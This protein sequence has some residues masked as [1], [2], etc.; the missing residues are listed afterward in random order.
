MQKPDSN[1]VPFCYNQNNLISNVVNVMQPGRTP[2]KEAP[3][4]LFNT[5]LE[6]RLSKGQSKAEVIREVSAAVERKYDNDRFYKWSMQKLTVAEP[7]LLTFI[8][9]ELP[10]VLKHF[11]VKNNYS[12]SGIDFE[13]LANAIRPAVKNLSIQ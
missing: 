5:W 11:Y 8:Y 6:Y 4:N 1:I 13:L 3:S 12:L 7:V 9:P 10:E 2:K